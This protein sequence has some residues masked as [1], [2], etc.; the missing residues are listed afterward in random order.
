M[1]LRIENSEFRFVFKDNKLCREL[2]KSGIANTKRGSD[3][4][5]YGDRN[6]SG[7]YV[8]I[9]NIELGPFDTYSEAVYAEVSFLESTNMKGQE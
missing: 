6:P 8:K 4:H 2:L 1:K 3:I 5:Y 7:W 9:M